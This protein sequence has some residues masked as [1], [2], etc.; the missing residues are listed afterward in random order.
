MIDE[1][2]K[3]WSKE[4]FSSEVR[5]M[6]TDEV[7]MYFSLALVDKDPNKFNPIWSIDH[8][9]ESLPVPLRMILRHAKARDLQ[10]SNPVLAFLALSGVISTPGHI[11][12]YCNALSVWQHEN[13]QTRIDM[14]T[15]GMKLFPYGFP[16]PTSLDSLW[17][18]MKSITG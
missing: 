4:F 3:S 14:E 6:T 7:E 9:D 12:M 2:F 15:L 17:D 16:S 10:I 11:S 18:S 13:E 5:S 8:D 1:K